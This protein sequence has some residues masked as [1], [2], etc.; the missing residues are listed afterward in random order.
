MKR[1]DKTDAVRV[2]PL[3]SICIP[4]CNSEKYLKTMLDSVVAQTYQN[5]EVIISDNASSDSTVAIAE[6]YAKEYG[7]L[8]FVNDKNLGAI[9]NFNR[10]I[11]LANGEYVAIYHSDD[12]YAPGIVEES[13]KI[14]REHRNVGIVST[15]GVEINEHGTAIRELKIPAQM[16]KASD[17]LYD[18]ETIFLNVLA[19]KA[20][21]LI[22]PSVMVRRKAYQELGRFDLG[23][24]SACDYEM[25]FRIMQKYRLC[26]INKKL[27]SYRVHEG[28]WSQMGIR[29]NLKKPDSLL[30]YE[31]YA[32][33]DPQR[34]QRLFSH[35]YY[36]LL[37]ILA[38]KLNNHGEF[39]ESDD[40]LADIQSKTGRFFVTI[41][42]LNFMNA[43]KVKISLRALL[44]AKFVL[45]KAFAL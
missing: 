13:C 7:W 34:F 18:F 11:D 14:L 21:F 42:A 39:H 15:L 22:T 31:E 19:Q 16:V 5:M 10:L 37:Y 29:E 4:T 45:K 20:V 32:N 38:I 24:A 8:L 36:K 25:W 27:I 12:I 6:V 30:V 33:K 35:S 3:V 17:D 23:Y 2:E 1:Q 26:L 43:L 41:K 9:G 44:R 40:V 28:Q